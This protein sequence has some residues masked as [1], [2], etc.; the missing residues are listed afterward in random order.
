MV[1]WPFQNFLSARRSCVWKGLSWQWWDLVGLFGGGTIWKE[2]MLVSYVDVILT[3]LLCL[4]WQVLALLSWGL[5]GLF[6]GGI[7]HWPYRCCFNRSPV[8]ESQQCSGLVGLF[9]VA[10]L[11]GMNLVTCESPRYNFEP[12]R[13]TMIAF[14]WFQLL[15]LY[16]I[17]HHHLHYHPHRLH[18]YHRHHH[19]PRTMTDSGLSRHAIFQKN[20]AIANI[21]HLFTFLFKRS[22][23]SLVCK[24]IAFLSERYFSPV[25]I[26]HNLIL[27]ARTNNNFFCLILFIKSHFLLNLMRQIVFLY[28]YHIWSQPFW[29]LCVICWV[30]QSQRFMER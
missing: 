26:R 15:P 7:M 19:V 21:L 22:W 23:R 24:T 10:A 14:D 28:N 30:A 17:Y 12:S 20:I 29:Q 4:K 18:Q 27:K 3:D 25:Q 8:L 5:V 16:H 6:G 1:H 11:S 13:R 2:H 9:G